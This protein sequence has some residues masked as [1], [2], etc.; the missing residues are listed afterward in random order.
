MTRILIVDD[1]EFI[2]RQLEQLYLSKGYE[3]R[4]TADGEEALRLL[5]SND[6]SL[7]IVDLA[8]PGSDG[9]L[10]TRDIRDRWP[11]IPVIMITG[12]AS[13]KGAVEAIK[14][15]ASDYVTKPFQKEEIE[16]AT[17]NVLEKQRLQDEVHY[18]R[19]E[20]S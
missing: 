12:Y 2:C 6:F 17:D 13:I 14:Q 20:L 16:L 1:D 7:V 10:L 15:G 3:A 19:S 5:A 18:L 4:S 8:I 9:M 11:E